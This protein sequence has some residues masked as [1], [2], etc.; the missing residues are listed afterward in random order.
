GL[1]Q[2][3]ARLTLRPGLFAGG[4]G[5]ANG[6]NTSD[7]MSGGG[8]ITILA[9]GGIF[10]SST[11]TIQANAQVPS[12]PGAGG[13]GGAGGIVIL[14]SPTQISHQGSILANGSDG[15][16]SGTTEAPGGGGG[17]GIVHLMS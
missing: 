8:S 9:Q 16:P 14:A 15:Q 13:G 6:T 5:S 4:A 17:G 7:G 10:I 1:G 2:L 12:G 3:Q 11:G